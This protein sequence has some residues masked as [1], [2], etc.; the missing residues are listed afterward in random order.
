[1]SSE[2]AKMIAKSIIDQYHQF[3]DAWTVQK[4]AS[5]GLSQGLVMEVISILENTS[6]VASTKIPEELKHYIKSNIE[7]CLKNIKKD[8]E[9]NSAKSHLAM[10]RE[11]GKTVLGVA[12]DK[13]AEK[14]YCHADSDKHV[15]LSRK[16]R[17]SPSLITF[18]ESTSDTLFDLDGTL[19]GID[20]SS[21]EVLN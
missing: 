16:S 10:L 2:R 15:L 3:D 11:P 14:Y 6:F 4:L 17:K 21:T 18:I 5:S 19:V 7:T 13:L 12:Y 8:G 9:D 1:M 20:H